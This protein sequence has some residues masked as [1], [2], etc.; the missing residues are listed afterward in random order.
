MYGKVNRGYYN[1]LQACRLSTGQLPHLRKALETELVLGGD[2]FSNSNS[3]VLSD[4]ALEPPHTEQS[5]YRQHR[6]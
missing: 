6:K 1:F 4:V 3:N 2:I 5:H